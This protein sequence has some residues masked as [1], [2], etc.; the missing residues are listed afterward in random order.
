M[1]TEDELYAFFGMLLFAGVFYANLQPANKSWA[2]YNMPIC[3]AKYVLSSVQTI[4]HLHP[5]R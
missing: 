2:S 3:K 5:L 1:T 4:D